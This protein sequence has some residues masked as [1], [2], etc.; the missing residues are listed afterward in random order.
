[1]RSKSFGSRRCGVGTQKRWVHQVFH[2]ATPVLVLALPIALAPLTVP[3][4][5]E[6]KSYEANAV[7]PMPI[8][9]P[10]AF[11]PAEQIIRRMVQEALAKG[12]FHE[13]VESTTM[14]R[15]L[16]E[17]VTQRLDVDL[18]YHLLRQVGVDRKMKLPRTL[19]SQDTFERISVGYRSGTRDNGGAWSCQQ[20]QPGST[21]LIGR[22]TYLAATGWPRRAVNLGPATWNGV[23]VWRLQATVFGGGTSGSPTPAQRGD[24]YI[25]R[26]N[27]TLL[28]ETWR[29]GKGSTASATYSRYG[30]P[31]HISLPDVCRH[32]ARQ[33]TVHPALTG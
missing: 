10:Q 32:H 14:G 20:F 7:G 15:G 31:V 12:T 17:I 29:P 30:A 8:S 13:R 22:S 2:R 11:P 27:E 1:M 26:S 33:A 21:R 6:T 9:H 16:R 3:K 4:M 24:L 5:H 19:L 18:R 25:A 28:G 23:P